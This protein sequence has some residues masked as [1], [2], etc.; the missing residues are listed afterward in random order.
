MTWQQATFLEETALLTLSEDVE[1]A[2]R[3]DGA[4]DAGGGGTEASDEDPPHSCA[5]M[6]VPGQEGVPHA[7]PVSFVQ[8]P[9][10]VADMQMPPS[11]CMLHVPCW[12]CVTVSEEAPPASDDGPEGDDRAIGSGPTGVGEEM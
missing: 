12:H 3:D 8:L 7:A 2:G 4:E 5:M 10:A 11:I 6:Q 1:E 9:A